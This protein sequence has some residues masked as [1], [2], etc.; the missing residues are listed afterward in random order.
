MDQV[1]SL[2]TSNEPLLDS[3]TSELGA[4]LDASLDA[5]SKAQEELETGHGFTPFLRV[6][7]LGQLEERIRRIR[8]ALHP[9]RNLPDDI[10]CSIFRECMP[11]RGDLANDFCGDPPVDSIAPSFPTWILSQVSRRWRQIVTS[12]PG[13]WATVAI[14]RPSL[15]N[16]PSHVAVYKLT[17]QLMRAGTIPLHV[18]ID[19][20]SDEVDGAAVTAEVPLIPILQASSHRWETLWLAANR[21]TLGRIQG[22]TFPCLR[23]LTIWCLSAP[24]EM[25][26][27]YDCKTFHH[28]PSL[29]TIT[30]HN[31]F[32]ITLDLHWKQITSYE[33]RNCSVPPPLS[34]LE[35]A[36]VLKLWTF[37]LPG[38]RGELTNVREL[39]ISGNDLAG[40][41]ERWSFPCMK[42]LEM[43]LR[44]DDA[45]L[46]GSEPPPL[47]MLSNA[48][49]TIQELN[50][51]TDFSFLE[52][53]NII[54][55]LQQFDNLKR[56]RLCDGA[57]TDGVMERLGSRTVED[58]LL[59][60]LTH[61]ACGPFTAKDPDVLA[62]LVAARKT[63]PAT[64]SALEEVAIVSE[65][66]E[67]GE[68]LWIQLKDAAEMCTAVQWSTLRTLVKVSFRDSWIDSTSI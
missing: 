58:A 48:F 65:A 16:V 13:L 22:A 8:Q 34:S 10:L 2:L 54:H 31:G 11:T 32:N 40:F 36:E 57:M 33:V 68:E 60:R 3:Q 52:T 41:F 45:E 46:E 28:A 6:R 14:S 19:A 63:F 21:Q 59:P 42:R 27:T 29:R 17:L 39:D 15:T 38:D 25:N 26:R 35:A 61:F 1:D 4:I 20:Y 49:H 67:E 66:G 5:L 18:F 62:E 51:S 23:R 37:D 55:F 24:S 44:F 53:E 30:H 7:E 43:Y 12:N 64:F 56:L 9:V 50:V 47:P